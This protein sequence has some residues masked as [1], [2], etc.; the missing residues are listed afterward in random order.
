MILPGTGR[1]AGAGAGTGA[2]FADYVH[3]NTNGEGVYRTRVGVRVIGTGSGAK[4]SRRPVQHSL[5]GVSVDKIHEKIGLSPGAP[6]GVGAGGSGYGAVV[7]V[8]DVTRASGA[9]SAFGS[10]VSQYQLS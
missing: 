9:G 2:G 3:I 10:A 4:G 6:R 7:S 5:V 8:V 1:S